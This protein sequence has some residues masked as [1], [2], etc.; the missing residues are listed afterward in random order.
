MIPFESQS[1]YPH[2]SVDNSVFMLQ[3]RSGRQAL[4]DSQSV[5]ILGIKINCQ[6]K[7]KHQ[8][9][10]ISSDYFSGNASLSEK[11]LPDS[12]LIM[13]SLLL[14]LFLRFLMLTR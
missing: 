4:W 1:S 14:V 2:N 6:D 10:F 9:L 7:S 13:A 5:L 11:L 12:P 3:R 8:K